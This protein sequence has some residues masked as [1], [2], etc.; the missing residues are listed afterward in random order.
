MTEETQKTTE[1]AAQSTAD[2]AGACEVFFDGAC[3]LCRAEI[4]FYQR[5]GSDA[6]FVD[7][8]DEGDVPDEIT[9]E[10]AL[11]RFHVRKADGTLVS[12]AAAF[13]ELWK[14]TPGWRWLGHIGALPPFVWIGEG[15]YR[16]FLIFRPSLQRFVRKVS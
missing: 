8:S 3:P 10:Q 5:S 9:R 11:G 4:G 14:A 1:S 6:A 15:L 16:V 2:A 7:V 12:G 13:A